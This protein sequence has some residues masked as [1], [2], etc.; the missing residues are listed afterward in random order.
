M[1]N[2]TT[3]VDSAGKRPASRAIPVE[4]IAL[5][6]ALLLVACLGLA[7]VFRLLG[8]RFTI[9]DDAYV[10]LVANK[11]GGMRALLQ[12]Y[13]MAQGR[14]QFLLGTPLTAWPLTFEQSAWFDILHYGGLLLAHLAFVIVLRLYVSLRFSLSVALIYISSRALLWEHDLLVA[15]PVYIFGIILSGL[16][17]LILLYAYKRTGRRSLF[18]CSL[19][20]LAIS[21]LG[22]EYQPVLSLA[23]YI[24]AVYRLEETLPSWHGAPN[25]AIRQTLFGAGC[26]FILYGLAFGIFRVVFP[27]GYD[28]NSISVANLHI[29]SFFTVL[30]RF[31]FAS[32]VVPYLLRPYEFPYWDQ[33]GQSRFS[34]TT[35]LPVADMFRLSNWPHFAVMMIVV[36][37]G[38]LLVWRAERISKRAVLVIGGMGLLVMFLPNALL[39]VTPKYRQWVESGVRAYAYSTISHFGFALAL[40]SLYEGLSLFLAR[41]R[42]GLLCWR[43]LA[44]GILASGSFVA[45]YSNALVAGAMKVNGDRW[46]AF[47]LL[48][49]SPAMSKEIEHKIL[50]A[51]RLWSYFWNGIP[52]D[53][54]WQEYANAKYRKDVDFRKQVSS[55]AQNG[56]VLFD[57]VRQDKCGGLFDIVAPT[58]VSAAGAWR[59]SALYLIAAHDPLNAFVG[60][61]TGTGAARYV[62][63]ANTT[64][65]GK[66]GYIYSI[67]TP[68]LDPG[69]IRV[70]CV[71][72]NRVVFQEQTYTFGE[73]LNF[74]QHDVDAL[75]GAGWSHVESF[76]RWTI[77]FPNQL[78]S[79]W[80]AFL[81][82]RRTKLSGN[83]QEKKTLPL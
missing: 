48:M 59:G 20:A 17:S 30:F 82:K 29:R 55:G 79:L 62:A 47:N 78:T 27:S 8:I 71:P 83:L 37:A 69:S 66:Q 42:G 7:A 81:A 57:Y 43:C 36:V 22:H 39:A 45:S 40:A 60:F 15:V 65:L 16:V 18:Y 31:S 77:S 3:P 28:G 80:L 52:V 10:A 33:V 67:A 50:I 73:M 51:P 64:R 75:L 61:R 63:I 58:S 49:A 24:I 23:A 41:F 14:I 72:E 34:Y 32:S 9:W 38:A 1:S 6:S 74:G 5:Y 76:G 54:Y 19:G 44:I 53:S 46:N 2:S 12:G 68:D 56:L 13:C 35:A 21:Y 26:L 70:D 4:Q 11:D 25:P